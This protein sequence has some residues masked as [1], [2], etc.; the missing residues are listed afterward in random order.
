MGQTRQ[1]DIK[2]FRMTAA[3]HEDQ[4]PLRRLTARSVI[5]KRTVAATRGNGRDAPKAGIKAKFVQIICLGRVRIEPDDR[6]C[7]AGVVV[8]EDA[9]GA[10]WYTV[11]RH[12]GLASAHA[13]GR[14]G[15]GAANRLKFSCQ[16]TIVGRLSMT[17][18]Q[19]GPCPP[20]SAS[21]TA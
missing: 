15:V 12:A 11:K 21:E 20:L 1:L 2:I 14:R 13:I 18:A 8:G 19:A 6:P 5:R 7:S 17:A 9:T 10:R 4:F 3:G 16:T